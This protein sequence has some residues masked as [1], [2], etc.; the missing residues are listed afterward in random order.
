MP[1]IHRKYALPGYE[2]RN[3]PSVP[4]EHGGYGAMRRGR[5]VGP[6]FCYANA[7]KLGVVVRWS[8]WAGADQTTRHGP[9]LKNVI[10][11]T[12]PLEIL[13]P[14]SKQSAVTK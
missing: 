12:Q 9:F 13:C 5:I 7:L 2:Q 4:W 14:K 11:A 6:F 8:D 10:S 1:T 3:G